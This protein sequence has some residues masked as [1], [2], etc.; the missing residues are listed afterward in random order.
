MV[1]G[2]V[3][4]EAMVGSVLLVSGP[5]QFE[6]VARLEDKT[7]ECVFCYLARETDWPLENMVLDQH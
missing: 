6:P 5:D 3:G 2:F 1:S 7:E 4:K